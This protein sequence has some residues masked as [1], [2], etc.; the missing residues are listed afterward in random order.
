M[1]LIK[2]VRDILSFFSSP[3]SEFP[4]TY[5]CELIDKGSTF[6]I[7]DKKIGLNFPAAA[8]LYKA[9]TLIHSPPAINRQ[10]DVCH[11]T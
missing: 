11:D 1:R 9:R 2:A 7:G 5:H 10:C 8:D 3:A 4:L 6:N